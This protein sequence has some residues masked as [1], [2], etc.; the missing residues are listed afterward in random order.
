[1]W[2]KVGSRSP[3]SQGIM[4]CRTSS[5]PQDTVNTKIDKVKNRTRLILGRYPLTDDNHP[6]Q[7][8]FYLQLIKITKHYR[9]VPMGKGLLC[10][11][12]H[13]PIYS[14]SFSQWIFLLGLPGH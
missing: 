9:R 10:L 6:G 13:L 14:Y 11:W 4:M 5:P 1:M 12:H 8:R 3:G 7:S 2:I